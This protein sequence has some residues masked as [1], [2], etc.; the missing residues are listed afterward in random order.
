MH[1][2]VGVRVDELPK[3]VR[4]VVWPH[5]PSSNARGR[6]LCVQRV[7]VG[8]IDVYDASRPT[9]VT[10]VVWD[11]VELHGSPF[12]E[13]VRSRL[14]QLGRK[15]EPLVSGERSP[16]VA[17]G[18]HRSDAI[19]ADLRH[20]RDGRRLRPSRT[21]RSAGGQRARADLANPAGALGG[22]I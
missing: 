21:V 17:D 7:G 3:A 18:Q 22:T 4:G 10:W 14:I 15:A 5:E 8:D 11:Q 1:D 20:S 16:K 6:P 9:R 13:A 12:D 19:E 2:A